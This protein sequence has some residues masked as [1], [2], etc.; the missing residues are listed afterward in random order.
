MSISLMS[1]M[2]MPNLDNFLMLNVIALSLPDPCSVGNCLVSSR[3]DLS[4]I[5]QSA[6]FPR[7]VSISLA[8]PH[9]S[10]VTKLITPPPK[11]F[12]GRNRPMALSLIASP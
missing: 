1:L 7:L 3:L 5:P 12:L 10:Y 8:L 2:K 4:A 6:G 9:R 11:D